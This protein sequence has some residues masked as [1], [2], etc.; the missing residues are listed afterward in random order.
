MN[1][2]GSKGRAARSVRRALIDRR[3][4][5]V[6]PVGEALLEA[7]L[8]RNAYNVCNVCNVCNNAYSATCVTYE[9]GVRRGRGL[10]GRT[11][12]PLAV[13]G[14]GASG[15]QLRRLPR[16]L[17]AGRR[18]VAGAELLAQPLVFLPR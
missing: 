15:G 8:P 7:C 1:G 9:R 4:L 5:R 12:L 13:A 10:T 17:R 6:Q 2:E 18:G 14:G 3:Q 16:R 11:R